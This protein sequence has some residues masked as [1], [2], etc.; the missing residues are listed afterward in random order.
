MAR[1]PPEMA[2][3]PAP[4]RAG[5]FG[6]ARTTAASVPTASSITAVVT[7]AAIDSTRPAPARPAAAAAAGT[8]PGFT[9]S[10]APSARPS[11][12]LVATTPGR[13]SASHSRRAATGST[14]TISEAEPQP[15]DTSPPTRAAPMLP[16]PNTTNLTVMP[17]TP[18]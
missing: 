18:S 14:T 17:T 13:A 16:P 10:R 5:V 2:A 7:P 1:R 11:N 8:S 9:A 15:D 4:T 6:M 12:P 3:A